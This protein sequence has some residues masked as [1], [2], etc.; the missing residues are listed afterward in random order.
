MAQGTAEARAYMEGERKGFEGWSVKDL[1]RHLSGR[2]I[3]S[4]AQKHSETSD[5]D[6]KTS[7]GE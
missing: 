5:H 7:S 2:K 6:R 4:V 3:S 1:R